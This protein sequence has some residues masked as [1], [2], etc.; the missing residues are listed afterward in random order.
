MQETNVF[1]WLR[2]ALGEKVFLGRPC[3]I[4]RAGHVSCEG[5]LE[6]VGLFSPGQKGLEEA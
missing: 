6:D 1:A 3:L 2:S 4:R 5:K